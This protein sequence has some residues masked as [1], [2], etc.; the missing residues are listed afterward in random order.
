MYGNSSLRSLKAPYTHQPNSLYW[1]CVKFHTVL[2]QV[3]QAL[4]LRQYCSVLSLP[5]WNVWSLEMLCSILCAVQLQST[6]VLDHTVLNKDSV[7]FKPQI[8]KTDCQGNRYSISKKSCRIG[9]LKS[10][11]RDFNQV[12]K[13]KEKKR[14][15][16][17]H[18][19][20]NLSLII[21]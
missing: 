17:F 1:I 3:T 12:T 19:V 11:W 21:L 10:K 16:T 13:R 6:K 20:N 9:K 4:Q 7:T 2:L 15:Q 18:D 5:K 8:T 14:K